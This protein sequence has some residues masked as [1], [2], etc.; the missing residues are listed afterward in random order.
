MEIIMF[1]SNPVVS[2][3]LS[4][5][6][7]NSCFDETLCKKLASLIE[8][9]PWGPQ[10]G[11]HGR[12]FLTNRA[13]DW[14]GNHCRTLWVDRVQVVHLYTKGSYIVVCDRKE[15]VAIRKTHRASNRERHLNYLSRLDEVV[16]LLVA[17][18]VPRYCEGQEGGTFNAPSG[19][20]VSARGALKR[21]FG[22]SFPE[23]FFERLYADGEIYEGMEQDRAKEALNAPLPYI[24]LTRDEEWFGDFLPDL[25]RIRG[26][27]A[28]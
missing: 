27:M 3:M 4:L 20:L 7:A 25:I 14:S 11:T 16:S 21:A 28:A 1:K 26:L 5:I 12:A 2:A 23:K 22:P 18:D 17:G 19:G 8:A 15:M 6:E 13:T 9:L 24:P 10:E